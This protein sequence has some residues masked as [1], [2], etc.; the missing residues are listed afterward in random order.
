MSYFDVGAADQLIARRG[1]AGT[2]PDGLG[3][4]FDTIGSIFK[5]GGQAALDVYGESQRNKG[6]AQAAKQIA[7]AQAAAQVAPTESSGGGMPSW[8]LPVAGIAAVGVVA[9]VVLK[10]RR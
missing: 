1:Y 2:E 8:V 4:L 7:K 6:Q 9:L 5:A 10:K 3:G